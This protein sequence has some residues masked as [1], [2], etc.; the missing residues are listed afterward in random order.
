MQLSK[1]A[2]V[3]YF[4]KLFL[5][6]LFLSIFIPCFFYQYMYFNVFLPVPSNYF[7]PVH[8]K[9]GFIIASWKHTAPH[10]LH[11]WKIQSQLWLVS[12]V[13]SLVSPANSNFQEVTFAMDFFSKGQYDCKTFCVL[14]WIILLTPA[15]IRASTSKLLFTHVWQW[16]SLK[17]IFLHV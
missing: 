5:F 11:S 10:C 3:L 4:V 17:G 16:Q 6:L 7:L 14:L 15:T 2:S 12:T 9:I 13:L 8:I 1:S